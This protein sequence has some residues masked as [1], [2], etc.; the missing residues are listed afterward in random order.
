MSAHYDVTTGPITQKF[1]INTYKTV[2]LNK[3]VLLSAER[4]PFPKIWVKGTVQVSNMNLPWCRQWCSPCNN[5]LALG[6]LKAAFFLSHLCLYFHLLCPQH[7]CLVLASSS[8]KMLNLASMFLSQSHIWHKFKASRLP[9]T[10]VNSSYYFFH[11][12]LCFLKAL[13]L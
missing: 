10:Q 11:C 6:D 1:G 9:L 2:S 4:G 7:F 13:Q 12:E 3:F 5:S 8:E